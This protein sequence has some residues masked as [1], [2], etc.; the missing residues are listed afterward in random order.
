MCHLRNN[1]PGRYGQVCLRCRSKYGRR[2]DLSQVENE[3]RRL[4]MLLTMERREHAAT[5]RKLE[6][7]DHDRQRYARRIRF[8][9]GRHDALCALYRATKKERD[10]LETALN[11]CERSLLEWQPDPRKD[12][13]GRFHFSEREY[14][15]TR[16]LFGIVSTFN[17]N[18]EQLER[19]VREIP[20]AGGI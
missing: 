14:Y 12:A 4:Q 3:N 6:K 19:R 16:E 5:R 11:A 15:A 8:L 9:D 2:E 20:G 10:I 17:K 13:D 18:A 7:A 1:A